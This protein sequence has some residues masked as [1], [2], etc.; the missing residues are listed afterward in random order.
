VLEILRE[1]DAIQQ[2]IE[3]A[4]EEGVSLEEYRTWRSARLIDEAFLQQDTSDRVDAHVSLQR[5]AALLRLLL[6]LFTGAEAL[7]DRVAVREHYAGWISTLRQLNYS[8]FGSADYCRYIAELTAGA[9][10]TG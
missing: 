5:M 7:G 10:R 2:M 1:G 8:E 3:V 4:G 6:G 9:S